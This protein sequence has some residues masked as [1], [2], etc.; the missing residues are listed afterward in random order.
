MDRT[1]CGRIWRC[2]LCSLTG[3][4]AIAM[5]AHPAVAGVV[6]NWGGNY[7]GN[8]QSF[9]DSGSTNLGGPDT[10]GDL[11]G[12]VAYAADSLGISGTIT[13]RLPSTSTLYNPAIGATYG[14]QSDSFY[15]GHAV[16]LSAPPNRGVSTLIVENQ[17]S[18]D[19]IKV[20][21]KPNADLQRFAMLTYWDSD[22]FLG[23]DDQFA[24]DGTSVFSLSSTQDAQGKDAVSHSLRWVIRQG[25]QFYLSTALPF[26]N[27]STYTSNIMSL[28][29]WT[30][31]DPYTLG[32]R[33]L[34]LSNTAPSLFA[35]GSLFNN[36]TAV[37]FYVEYLRPADRNGAGNIDYKIGGFNA[38]LDGSAVPE[39]GT[40]LFGL[41]GFGGIALRRW[42]QRRK[43]A[44]GDVPAT[45]PAG[46]LS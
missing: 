22:D 46:G 29:N 10:Y 45:D 20:E 17:G 31:Y 4:S 23:D 26:A 34:F 1:L 2:V 37:G 41:A 44:A 27:S 19:K 16:V 14:G 21:V 13:G 25:T 15:G 43:T 30:L 6:V 40:F 39:P 12:P 7:V 3:I 11:H 35:G 33:S 24:V 9:A 18:D 8:S 36:V 28:T 42:R 32:L 5:M 38:T